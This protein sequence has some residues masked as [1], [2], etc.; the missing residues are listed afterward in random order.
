MVQPP[1]WSLAWPGL[2]ATLTGVGFARFSYTA[3]IPFLVGAGEVSAT[4]A[5][6]LGAANLAGYFIGAWIASTLARR[7]GSALSIRGSFVL[8]AVGL[9]LCVIPGG[10]WWIAPWRL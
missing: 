8:T 4:Q 3:L 7:L 2:C 5:D 6:Y 1:W 10:F 9:G